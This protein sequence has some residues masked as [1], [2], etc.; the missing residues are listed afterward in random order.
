MKILYAVQATGNGHI[1][2]AMELLP[3]LREYGEVDIFLSGANSTLELDAP[4]RYRSKGLSLFYTCNGGLNYSRIIRQLSL[5]RI[6][7]EIRELPVEQYDL[8]LN[9]FDCITALA[10]SR[11]KVRSLNFGH[12][13][14]FMSAKTPRPDKVSKTGEWIL[15]NYA[16]ATHYTG[17]HF[18]QY[19]DFILTPVIKNAIFEATPKNHGHIT[20]YLPSY[21]Q[22]E[23]LQYFRPLRDHYF[24]IFCHGVL[25]PERYGHMKFMPVSKNGFNESMINCS[26]IICGAGFETPAEALHLNKKMMVMPIKG[27]YEQCC[28]AAALARLGVKSITCLDAGFYRAFSDWMENYR[29]VSVR[30]SM[31]TEQIVEKVMELSEERFGLQWVDPEYASLGI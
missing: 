31:S 10:C 25:Q 27:Q 7:K 15:K 28:N 8:V 3:H 23:L 4:V 14:S 1:S 26:A 17:L 19:D 29:Q 21:C 20:V 9:D 18:E 30:Y 24:H 11:K 22:P 2:R 6:R 13:A 16:R 5:A 12:Q